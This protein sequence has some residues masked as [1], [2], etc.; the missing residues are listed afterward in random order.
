VVSNPLR[1]KSRFKLYQRF[2]E[3][4]SESGAVLITVEQ[5]FGDRHFAVTDA[6]NSHHV[7]VRSY[8]ELWHKEN[9]INLGFQRVVQLYPDA[10]YLAWIDADVEFQREDWVNET[11]H[12]LQHFQVVQLFQQAIDLGPEGEAFKIH[13]SFTYSY[14]SGAPKP[15]PGQMG[16]YYTASRNGIFNIWH[17][18]YCWAARREAIDMLGGLYDVS[19]LGSGDHLMAWALIGEGVKQLPSGM[20]EGYKESLRIWEERAE[21]FVHRDIGYV[22]GTILHHWHGKKRDRNYKSRW[23]ILEDSKFDPEFDIKRDA[24]GLYQWNLDGSRRMIQLR[25]D[26]RRYFRSRNEDSIDMES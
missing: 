16:D 14:L 9:M 26:V 19:I 25:D 23:I 21:K 10:E 8:D 7:Q 11:L 17:P 24:Q 6:R 18:G 22:N 20:S 12:Q 2:A 13:T 4:M 15:K 3:H 1:F 5:A